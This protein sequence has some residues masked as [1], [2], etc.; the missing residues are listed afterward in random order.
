M[1]HFIT[2]LFG[3]IAFTQPRGVLDQCPVETYDSPTKPIPR[4][5]GVSLQNAVVAM[6][7]MCALNSKYI[8]DSVASKAP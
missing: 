6:L 5:D 2:L 7:V 8:T 3:K 4:R 1:Q